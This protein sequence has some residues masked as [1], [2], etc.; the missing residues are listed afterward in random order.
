M[1]L[2][3]AREA[4]AATSFDVEAALKW[5]EDDL[6]KSGEKK[7][8][9]LEGRTAG[10][11]LVGVVVLAD[12]SP[13]PGTN[14]APR[15][16]RA[17]MVEL[18]CETD[19]VARNELFSTLALD[20]AHTAAF[21]AEAP[22]PPSQSSPSDQLIPSPS[23]HSRALVQPL[24][25][26]FLS[27]AILLSHSTSQLTSQADLLRAGTVSSA[28]RDAMTKLG[29]KISLRRVVSVV[30]DP[31]VV[32]GLRLGSF[33]HGAVNPV[34]GTEHAKAGAIGGLVTIGIEGPAEA[35]G[36]IEAAVSSEEYAADV[37]KLA[38]SAARQV[39]GL[40]TESIS[41]PSQSQE[42]IEGSTVLY[43]QPAM[44]FQGSSLPV[45]EYLREWSSAKG[46]SDS[47]GVE[48]LQFARWKAGEGIESDASPADF[49]EEVR[50]LQQGN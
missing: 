9:K 6:V 48:V 41:S 10:C 2:Q 22:L 37:V 1:S 11:G 39:V 20:I 29:E 43:D 38:R 36:K 23:S 28:I 25:L 47:T 45:R 30:C 14:N 21:L 50:R 27:S 5:I 7:A 31:G 42:A 26:P 8:A 15:G 46:L 16:V 3:K 17:A 44:M 49:A 40:E 4:L 12:G 24:P 32:P 35:H 19:F 13:F 18:N 33:V 34:K